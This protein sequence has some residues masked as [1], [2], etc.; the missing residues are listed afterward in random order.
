MFLPKKK[1]KKHILV[2]QS[3]EDKQWYWHLVDGNNRIV[4]DGSE[5]YTRPGD[6][7]RAAKNARSTMRLAPIWRA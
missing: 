4:A 6:C 2:Q 5:G 3:K 1:K 7:D